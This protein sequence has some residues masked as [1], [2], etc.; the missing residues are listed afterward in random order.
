M[1]EYSFWGELWRLETKSTFQELP[2]YTQRLHIGQGSLGSQTTARQLGR[3]DATSTSRRVRATL[4][5]ARG[6][7]HPSPTRGHPALRLIE[8]NPAGS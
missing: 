8:I 4:E 1:A 7:P 2:Y 3:T 6:V 5:E